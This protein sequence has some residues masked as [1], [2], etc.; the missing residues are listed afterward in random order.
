[1]PP[2]EPQATPPTG[3]V[4]SPNSS[5]VITPVEPEHASIA[6]PLSIVSL[7]IFALLPLA[8]VALIIGIRDIK[9]TKPKAK[10]AVII[11]VV[12]IVV[13]SALYIK[14]IADLAG[15][16]MAPAQSVTTTC[17]K[18]TI[19]PIKLAATVKD[20]GNC[21]VAISKGSGILN[22]F[23]ISALAD[24]GALKSATT[25]QIDQK[26]KAASDA[27]LAGAKNKGL[28]LATPTQ[29]YTAI[30]GA[31]AYQLTATAIGPLADTGKLVGW[32]V[33]YAPK[34]YT[35]SSGSSQL[36]SWYFEGDDNNT[37]NLQTVINSWKWQ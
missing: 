23:Q 11:S 16:K 27:I 1:M 13:S 10:A 34:A 14:V 25:D 4:Q 36:F 35:T 20:N 19:P 37:N 22:D 28:D 21:N 18:F 26:L 32:D 30:D 8:I 12:A 24:N 31:R 3:P 33:I 29:G 15:H 6:F 7:V 5:P 2:T 9:K 17:Y